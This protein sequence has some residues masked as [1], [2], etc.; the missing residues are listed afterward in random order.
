MFLLAKGRHPNDPGAVSWR[1][2]RFA[3]FWWSIL[4]SPAQSFNNSFHLHRVWLQLVTLYTTPE[5]YSRRARWPGSSPPSPKC[6]IST[7]C[8]LWSKSGIRACSES[9]QI[10]GVTLNGQ[11]RMVPPTCSPSQAD[12]S[13]GLLREFKRYGAAGCPPTGIYIP[14]SSLS[15]LGGSND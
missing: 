1:L 11:A 10:P 5:P 6:P 14:I 3:H 13:V 15:T 8:G 2:C 7:L 12:G 4:L 9:R